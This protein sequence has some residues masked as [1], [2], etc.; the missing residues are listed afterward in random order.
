MTARRTPASVIVLVCGGLIAGCAGGPAP[1][2]YMADVDAAP[3]T[4]FD[5][6][7]VSNAVP[8]LEPR[9][10]YGN[11]A[12]YVVFGKQ[13]R[14]MEDA[15]GFRERGHASWYG[16]KFHGRRT[17]SGEPYDMYKMTAAHKS[18]PLPSYVKVTNLRNGKSAI[19]RVNDRGPFHDGRIIDL[20]YAAALKLDV[21]GTGTA[22]VE[23]VVLDPSD[24]ADSDTTAPAAVK[25]EEDQQTPVPQTAANVFIQL[26]AFTQP[27]NA[28]D[29]KGRLE[30]AGIR[31]IRID[32]EVERQLFRVRV[33][34]FADSGL[35]DETALKLVALG[36][37]DFR[38]VTE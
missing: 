22:P 16:T 13:Y 6:S 17:S 21:V 8:R 12:T 26:G 28:I 19:V 15:S 27:D 3:A 33:G 36:I 4:P 7:T 10:R 20:S 11:P 18:L 30:Q 1:P 5:V 31:P 37:A 38:I 23:I 9:S 35:A 14:V 29:L 34:P 25:A 32:E 2:P 24:F